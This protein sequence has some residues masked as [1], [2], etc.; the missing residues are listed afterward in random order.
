MVRGPQS[1]IPLPSVNEATSR[2]AESIALNVLEDL[3]RSG[4][5]EM[6]CRGSSASTEM[7]YSLTIKSHYK[8]TLNEGVGKSH[9]SFP[10]TVITMSVEPASPQGCHSTLAIGAEAEDAWKYCPT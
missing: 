3:R 9:R 5:K 4:T 2:S 8:E 1:A 10:S 7:S 6:T